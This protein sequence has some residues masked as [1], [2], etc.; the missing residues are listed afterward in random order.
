MIQNRVHRQT[1][2]YSQFF[3]D[4][5]SGSAVVEFVILAIPLF[6]PI[7]IYLSQFAELSDAETK[8]R[9]LV[10]EVVRAYVSSEH[11]EEAEER[12]K[13]VLNYGAERLRFTS[14]EIRSMKIS[15]LCSASPC[16]TPGSRVRVNL[17]FNLS[18]NHR[19]IRVSAQEYVSPWQ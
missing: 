6:L 17:T 15:F 8:A 19:R 14:E 3:K 1:K 13:L 7:V 11:I 5:Q 10:R 16:L 2:L 12:S 9:S 18:Q 4:L